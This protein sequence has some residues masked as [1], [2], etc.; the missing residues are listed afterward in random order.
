MYLFI[1]KS[2]YLN[3]VFIVNELYDL[4]KGVILIIVI[5]VLSVNFCNFLLS[6]MIKSSVV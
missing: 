5:S 6:V 3:L 2:L 4:I 1:L